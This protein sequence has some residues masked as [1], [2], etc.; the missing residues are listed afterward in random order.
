MQSNSIKRGFKGVGLGLF[1]A[2][3]IISFSSVEAN[4]QWRDR[5]G[6][7]DRYDRRDNRRND[8]WGR[9]NGGYGGYNNNGIFNRARQQGYQDGLDVGME[10]SRDNR[11]FDPGSS[12]RYRN[13]TNGYESWMRDRDAY[14]N[15]YRRAF[16][17]GYSE[18]YRRYGRGGNNRRGGIWG[19]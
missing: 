17:Q 4:A 19:W 6:R 8:R 9:N 16:E 7:D 14:R 1:L 13:A 18:G 2:L 5:N 15:A 3:G 11:R 10:Q 12:S